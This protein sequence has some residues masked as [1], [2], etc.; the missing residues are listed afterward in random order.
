MWKAGKVVLRELVAL[1]A[2]LNK[3]KKSQIRCHKSH[4]S[5][6]K[7]QQRDKEKK[8][9]ERAHKNTEQTISKS[10]FFEAMNKI[11]KLVPYLIREK[12]N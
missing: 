10:R 1:H 7:T 4:H 8:A 2:Y 11:N 6:H 5:K 12:E 3:E 9:Q